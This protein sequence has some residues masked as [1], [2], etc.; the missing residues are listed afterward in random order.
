[1]QIDALDEAIS[2]IDEEIKASIKADEGLAGCC[3]SLA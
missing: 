1:M 3:R 2:I